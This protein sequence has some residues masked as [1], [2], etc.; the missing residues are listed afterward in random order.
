MIDFLAAFTPVSPGR[1]WCPSDNAGNQ[2][3]DHLYFLKDEVA[4]FARVF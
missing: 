3:S 4:H 1:N 2:D